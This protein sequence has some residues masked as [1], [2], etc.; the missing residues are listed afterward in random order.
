MNDVFFISRVAFRLEMAKD[1]REG[2]DC[3]RTVLLV[4]SPLESNTRGATILLRRVGRELLGVEELVLDAVP[5]F[6]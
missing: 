4:L 3:Q 6:L 5:R 2:Q 1:F